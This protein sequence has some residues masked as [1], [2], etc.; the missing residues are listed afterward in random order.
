[1]H[2][3]RII[4]TIT[5]RLRQVPIHSAILVFLEKVGTSGYWISVQNGATSQGE[6]GS[7]GW[8]TT[9]ASEMS[10]QASERER[11][12]GWSCLHSIGIA[13]VILMGP[14]S[15]RPRSL[16][17]SSRDTAQIEQNKGTPRRMRPCGPPSPDKNRAVTAPPLRSG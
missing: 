4:W 13:G 8:T 5:L 1:M 9:T 14:T 7:E 10:V 16:A 6:I 2:S 3:K 17:P 11:Y 15:C 12:R